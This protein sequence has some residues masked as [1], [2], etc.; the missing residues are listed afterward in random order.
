MWFCCQF[1]W[2]VIIENFFWLLVRLKKQFKY[3][4]LTS[5]IFHIFIDRMIDDEKNP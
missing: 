1:S 4:D 3:V 5:D 2:S